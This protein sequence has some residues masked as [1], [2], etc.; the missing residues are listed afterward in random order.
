MQRMI[1][2]EISKRVPNQQ[3]VIRDAMRYL[4]AQ[5]FI[6]HLYK[7]K[8]HMTRQELL[9]LC[10]QALNGDIDGAMRGLGTIMNRR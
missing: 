5:D 7:C 3:D 10:G 2:D 9:T 4:R 6:K 1:N 8:S